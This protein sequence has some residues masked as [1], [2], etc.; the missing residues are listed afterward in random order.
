MLDSKFE[1]QLTYVKSPND[2]KDFHDFKIIEIIHNEFTQR[3]Q[4]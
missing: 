3:A 1:H 4:V 2:S